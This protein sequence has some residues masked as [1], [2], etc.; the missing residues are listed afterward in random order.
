MDMNNATAA[1]PSFG[2]FD[3]LFGNVPQE[4]PQ[5]D[6]KTFGDLLKVV[7]NLEKDP[8]EQL[9][10]V[11]PDWTAKEIQPG[12]PMEHRF[13]NTPGAVSATMNEQGLSAQ[14]LAALTPWMAKGEAKA[15][16]AS[17]INAHQILA[18]KEKIREMMPDVKD[19]EIDK[20]VTEDAA[21]LL[22]ALSAK[23]AEIHA[24]QA[25]K[26]AGEGVKAPLIPNLPA[27]AKAE[28]A[29]PQ[30]VNRNP[31]EVEK[32]LNDLMAKAVKQPQAK[33]VHEE[34]LPDAPKA[35]PA[36][37]EKI[38]STEDYLQ[39]QTAAKEAPRKGADVG[40]ANAPQ[41]HTAMAGLEGGRKERD[42][43]GRQRSRESDVLKAGLKKTDLHAAAQPFD[44]GLKAGGPILAKEV[45][46]PQSGP[47]EMRL[48]LVNELAQNVRLQARQGGGE[49]RLLIKPEGLGELRLK[50]GANKD[51][52]VEVS[53]VATN[54]EVARMLRNG[55][56]ELSE[57]LGD[58]K[59]SLAKFDVSVSDKSVAQM[60]DAR[61]GN[62]DQSN[63]NQQSLSQWA[64]NGRS[65]ADHQ[66]RNA[67]DGY[68]AH[69]SAN[70]T[71]AHAPVKPKAAQRAAAAK[72][73]N[74]ID[75]VA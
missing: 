10:A 33:Q 11:E 2:L 4:N 60:S 37:Q 58:Q 65:G 8:N 61:G 20:L 26:P 46:L 44:L 72:G 51:G 28:K 6:G 23:K 55:S 5:A 71:V 48:G 47:Q 21:R 39:M 40:L 57:A 66:G 25:A 7:K 53:V 38:L 74:L 31:G 50:V 68:Q 14:S 32:S 9:V 73:N 18:I 59:L 63:L 24:Q 34:V 36:Q 52:Q 29:L 70:Q 49:M 12:E 42:S 13:G 56:N 19:E 64:D 43:E 54:D 75:V 45:L 41:Q 69:D 17:D 30:A 3:V 27:Q 22:M 67:D 35:L 15:L 1:G 62:M 16:A